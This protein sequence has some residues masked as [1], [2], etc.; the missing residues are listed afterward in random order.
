[1][2]G[3]VQTGTASEWSGKINE[4]IT[5]LA[6]TNKDTSIDWTSKDEAL[7]A[8]ASFTKVEKHSSQNS[9]KQDSNQILLWHYL[10][11]LC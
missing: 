6:T 5:N 8:T 9:R 10:I 7:I 2:F 1:M 11:D 4:W 3:Y